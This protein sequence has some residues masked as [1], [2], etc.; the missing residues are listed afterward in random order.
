MENLE[1]KTAQHQK[2]TAIR[3]PSS[4]YRY[5]NHTPPDRMKTPDPDLSPLPLP[6]RSPS[7]HGAQEASLSAMTAAST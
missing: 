3:D 2:A 7:T 5:R 6:E 1:K 4:K